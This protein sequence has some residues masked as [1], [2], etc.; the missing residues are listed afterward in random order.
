MV[1][2]LEKYIQTMA[3]PNCD[4]QMHFRLLLEHIS[5]PSFISLGDWV[6]VIAYKWPSKPKSRAMGSCRKNV[7]TALPV[8]LGSLSLLFLLI[9]PHSVAWLRAVTSPPSPSAWIVGVHHALALGFWHR[10]GNL[11]ERPQGAG[12][13][14]VGEMLVAQAW[15]HELPS[16]APHVKARGCGAE[17]RDG[18]AVTVNLTFIQSSFSQMKWKVSRCLI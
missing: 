10:G 3:Q 14:V 17:D 7:L 4:H 12:K 15:G 11:R 13:L 18:Q 5:G 2:L 1:I 9:R 6:A 8:S 16:S